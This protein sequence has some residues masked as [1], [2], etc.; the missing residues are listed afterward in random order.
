MNPDGAMTPTGPTPLQVTIRRQDVLHF[1]G[2]PEGREPA[3]PIERRLD[4]V[5]AE[6]RSLA[7]GRGVFCHLPADAA[8][9]LGLEA[10]AAEQLVTGLV[11]VGGGIETRATAL[12]SEGDS[13]G[14]LLLDAAGSAAVEEAADRL[15]AVIAGDPGDDSA[16]DT[17]EPDE[18]APALSCRISPGYGRWKLES[19]SALFAT[20][21]HRELGVTLLPSLLM[22][23]RKSIS[24]AMWL[25]A[26]ARPVA[27]LS[28]CDRCLLTTCRYRKGGP[29]GGP[30]S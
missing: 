8:S 2:Y 22:T 19:Q 7:D 9:A 6:A 5:L 15:G 30:D 27:G 14:A 1:L 11:T 3:G 13:V 4:A 28:G 26:D 29:T 25:G 21:P 24:F 16:G 20:L 23:P 17:T 12:L 18:D 10:I